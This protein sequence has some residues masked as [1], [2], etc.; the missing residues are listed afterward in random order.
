MTLCCAGVVLWTLPA[1]IISS[2][3]TATDDK[4]QHEKNS[5][6]PAAK[7]IFNF[8]RYE[9]LRRRAHTIRRQDLEQFHCKLALSYLIFRQSL[10][11][12]RRHHYGLS[13]ELSLQLKSDI[14]QLFQRLQA[15]ENKIDGI[16]YIDD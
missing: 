3:L 11:E 6:K 8:W 9:S 15:I 2:S 4:D 14:Q 16:R 1:G 5:K 10:R 7:L 12:F 13:Y